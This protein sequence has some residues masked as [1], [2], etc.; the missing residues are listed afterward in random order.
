MCSYCMFMYLSRANWHSSATLTE[1]FPCFFLCYKANARIYLAKTGHGLHSSKF[2]CFLYI[3][4]VCKCVLY[5]CR[6][7]AT[8]LQL[9]N[10]S[11]HNISH[12]H[13]R[14]ILKGGYC[15]T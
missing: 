14:I 1:V 12:T 9:T 10:I 3:F 2:F 6:R 5:Y 11:Y 15:G 7:E 4:F 13:T 8:Q